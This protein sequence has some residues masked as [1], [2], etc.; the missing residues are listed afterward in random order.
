MEGEEGREE[1]QK[2]LCVHNLYISLQNK[3]HDFTKE[4]IRIKIFLQNVLHS[5]ILN[6][7]LKDSPPLVICLAAQMS[8]RTLDHYQPAPASLQF[9]HPQQGTHQA[10]RT[11]SHSKR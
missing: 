1:L 11:E 6:T 4:L 9:T 5:I 10:C 2:D 7:K 3:I 8:S